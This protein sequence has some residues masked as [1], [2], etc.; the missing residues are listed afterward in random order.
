[1]NTKKER[2]EAIREIIRKEKLSCQEDLLNALIN[3]GFSLTQAT[4]SRDIRTLKIAKYPDADGRYFYSLPKT[5]NYSGSPIY[6][7]GNLAANR[8]EERR[9]GKECRS[10]WSPY[11]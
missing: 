1:M 4:L 2:L 3:K 9:V 11:H 10:R 6:Q 8:S 5:N 7:S